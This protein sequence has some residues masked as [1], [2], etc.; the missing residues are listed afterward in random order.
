MAWTEAERATIRQY[1][2]YGTLY[3]QTFSMLEQAI[4]HVQSIADGGARPDS[5]TETL[6]RGILT[7]IAACLARI[8]ENSGYLVAIQVNKIRVD[9]AR[10]IAVDRQ[11]GRGLVNQLSIALQTA[12]GADI[13]STSIETDT[14]LPQIHGGSMRGTGA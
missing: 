14:Y 6:V 5:T 13:F 2:G 8:E 12:P 10:A 11:N 1:L 4:S 3:T 9:A 7:K